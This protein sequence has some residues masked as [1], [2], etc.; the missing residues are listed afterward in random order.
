MTLIGIIF[1]SLLWLKDVRESFIL[2]LLWLFS[3]T[4]WPSYCFH[5]STDAAN[6]LWDKLR[7]SLNMFLLSPPIFMDNCEISHPNKTFILWF[8]WN[9]RHCCTDSSSLIFLLLSFRAVA[10][11]QHL[12][13]L[14]IWQSISIFRYLLVVARI[15]WSVSDIFS[16]WTW[17]ERTFKCICRCFWVN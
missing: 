9:T 2:S 5:W 11:L 15:S 12:F 13:I 3:S 8:H 1:I 4:R 7:K 17:P 6:L 14:V 10:V 16:V